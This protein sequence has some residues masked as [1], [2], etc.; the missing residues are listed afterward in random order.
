[1]KF[2]PERID[3]QSISGYGPGWVAVGSEKITSSIIL[4]A[5]GVRQA[6]EV[7]S[8]EQLTPEHFVQ[9]ATLEAEVMLLGTGERT[10]F[11]PPKWL[12]P[13]F[14]RRIGLETMD[15]FAACRTYNI[16]AAEGRNVLVALIIG[17]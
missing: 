15:S 8:F 13:L 14:A 10:R 2:S 7:P 6:W 1:M 9:L 3:A 12:A 17:A 4:G 5:N 11:V 16:L